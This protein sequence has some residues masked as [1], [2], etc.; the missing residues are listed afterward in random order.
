MVRLVYVSVGLPTGVRD[1]LSGMQVIWGA[2]CLGCQVSGVPIVGG[3][4][5]WGRIDVVSFFRAVDG[6]ASFLAIDAVATECSNS[7]QLSA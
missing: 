2:S 3:P 7:E 4:V 1:E 6:Q 5:V